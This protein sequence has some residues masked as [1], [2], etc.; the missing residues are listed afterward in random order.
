MLL[1]GRNNAIQVK[2]PSTRQ[3][4]PA[5][6]W[7]ALPLY[8]VYNHFSLASHLCDFCPSRVHPVHVV[9][10]LPPAS[11]FD[12]QQ[13]TVLPCLLKRASSV[14]GCLCHPLPRLRI[15]LLHQCHP[16]MTPTWANAASVKVQLQ[17]TIQHLPPI[18]APPPSPPST[19][20]TLTPSVTSVRVDRCGRSG[21]QSNR[22]LRDLSMRRP[23]SMLRLSTLYPH[24]HQRMD[25]SIVPIHS[26]SQSTTTL[27]PLSTI[28]CY[29]RP[30]K[31]YN[32]WTMV[33]YKLCIV[34]TGSIFPG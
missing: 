3:I 18:T 17:T 5:T 2:P 13:R 20:H 1:C 10:T 16:P 21:R 33:P 34:D 26:H 4:T 19:S 25:L 31:A 8:S 29:Y 27:L 22:V 12:R 24:T 14:S 7:P 15:R 23:C 30:A 32:V 9:V 28:R 11:S 6:Y